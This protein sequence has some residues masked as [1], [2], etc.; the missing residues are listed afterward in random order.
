MKYYK[1]NKLLK[2]T[3]I[4]L[5]ITNVIARMHNKPVKRQILFNVILFSKNERVELTLN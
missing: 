1:N 3:N 4:N 2:I 5:I